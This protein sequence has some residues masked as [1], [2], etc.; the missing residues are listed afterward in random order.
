VIVRTVSC[1]NLHLK[2]VLTHAPD[3]QNSSRLQ[4]STVFVDRPSA[5]SR[6]LLNLALSRSKQVIIKMEENGPSSELMSAWKLHDYYGISS[7]KLVENLPIPQISKAKD[8]VVEV[9]AASLN[10]LDVL[11]TGSY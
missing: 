11:M 10:N 9:R 4:R 6:P 8:M 3:R 2:I 5:V 1:C 7:L